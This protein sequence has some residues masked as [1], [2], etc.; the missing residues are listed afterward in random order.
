M[1]N[2]QV[3]TLVL[4]D[5]E[6]GERR[7]IR[8]GAC[9]S[10]PRLGF[11]AHWGEL[12]KA[13]D[14]MSIPVLKMTG[15]SWG[16]S[17]QRG[18][19][20]L[21][22]AGCDYVIT[23]DYDSIFSQQDLIALLTLAARYQDADAIFPWQVKRGGVDALLLG[24]RDAEGN[25][26]HHAPAHVFGNEM[27]LC[28]SGHFGL[29]LIKTEALLKT[30]KPWFWEQPNADGDWGDGKE[31]A[32]MYFWRK[33]RE[34]GNLPCLATNVR[35]GHIDEDILWPTDCLTV[36]RQSMH[37]Y[38][39][40]GRPNLNIAAA[41]I[42]I[43]DG[44]IK[45]NLGSGGCP[46]EGWMNL[47]AKDGHWAFPLNVP[48]GMADEIRASHILEHFP[49]NAVGAVVKEWARALKPGGRLKIAVPD[50][51]YIVKAYSNGRRHDKMLELYLFGGQVDA[52]DY[53]K[54]FFN[55]E[56]LRAILTDAGL[57]DVKRWEADAQ[58][59]SAY[60][61][62][63]NLEGRKPQP[64]PKAH[65]FLKDAKG[66]IHVGAN[67]GQERD[68][69][70]SHNLPVVWIEAIAGAFFELADNIQGYPN[71]RALQ[72]LVADEDGKMYNFHIANNGGQAS[73]VFEFADHTKIW[74]DVAQTQS[75]KHEGFTLKTILQRHAVDVADYDTLIIDVQGAELLVLKG[76]D[77]DGFKHIV[78]EACDFEMYKGGCR[79]KDL[80]EY[81][82][83]RGFERVQTWAY[84][85]EGTTDK[86]GIY[87]AV[88]KRRQHA[89]E[90]GEA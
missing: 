71:Q 28:A 44:P 39:R 86:N 60:Q 56:K 38:Q 88:Y 13:F 11:T 43:P 33:F 68:A 26:I 8:V 18:I 15:Y 2:F 31:D 32:D 45:L 17:L 29:T 49:H 7:D 74:P 89:N 79:L 12:H 41:P 9:T 87:E 23:I 1:L 6:T 46:L 54:A 21:V 67:T 75:L 50:F 64:I 16:A 30:P 70:A 61:V 85:R 3:K 66:V 72:Y 53:H 83:P 34:A 90:G 35:I 76:A 52:N 24:L 40:E 14:G 81:L 62:S 80:D 84:L 58:D 59:C 82:I 78:A 27:T 19:Q 47:D 37:E 5:A 36:A 4:E 63:L 77:L 48:D 57:G 22:D 51:D 10:V 42:P 55:E 73:S 25:P 69:Y 65:D 20:M